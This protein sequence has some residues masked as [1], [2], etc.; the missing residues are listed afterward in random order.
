VYKSL[1]H[2]YAQIIDDDAGATLVT[3]STLDKALIEQAKGSNRASAEAVGAL[4]A[5]R[6]ADQGVKKVVFDRG[7]YPYHGVVA[8]LADACRKGGLEF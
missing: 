2:I 8:A 1:R 3:A 4:L 5:E 7:G 6:A